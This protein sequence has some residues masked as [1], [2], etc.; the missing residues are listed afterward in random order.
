M[1]CH[2]KNSNTWETILNTET[3]M[4]PIANDSVVITRA[5]ESSTAIALTHPI[6]YFGTS[7]NAVYVRSVIFPSNQPRSP[8]MESSPSTTWSMI[9]WRTPPRL[10]V[11]LFSPST[12]KWTMPGRDSSPTPLSMVSPLSLARQ[13]SESDETAHS[14]LTRASVAAGSQFGL[15]GFRPRYLHVFTFDKVRQAGSGN[16]SVSPSGADL[17]R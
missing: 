9:Y 8:R 3:T 13:L 16:V 11:L 1:E 14:V 17:F 4:Y 15:T 7:Y 12:P 2:G 6:K 5:P 10:P